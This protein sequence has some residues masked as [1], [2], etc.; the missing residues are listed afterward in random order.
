MAF[1][2]SPVNISLTQRNNAVS[3]SFQSRKPIHE[4][5]IKLVI[6]VACEVQLSREYLLLLDP[7]GNAAESLAVVTGGQTVRQQVAAERSSAKNKYGLLLPPPRTR[8]AN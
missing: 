4:P 1:F 6:K 5:A 8:T 7:G 2:I 3:V